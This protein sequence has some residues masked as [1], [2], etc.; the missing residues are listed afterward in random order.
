MVLLL[1]VKVFF[2]A[3]NLSIIHKIN[4]TW[5]IARQFTAII[6]KEIKLDWTISPTMTYNNVYVS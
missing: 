6:T 5:W 1:G 2:Q 3:R 4:E